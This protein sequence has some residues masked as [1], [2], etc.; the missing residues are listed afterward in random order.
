MEKKPWPILVLAMIHFME[1]IAKIFFYSWLWNQSPTIF[2]EPWTLDTAYFRALFFFGFPIAGFAIYMVKNWSLPVFMGVQAVTLIGHIQNFSR[3]PESFPVYLVAGVTALNCLVVCYF[4][5]PAVRA[6]YL[7]PRLRW[8]EAKPRYRVNWDFKCDLNG[9]SYKGHILNISE[10]GMFLSFQSPQ[11]F[12][13]YKMA[14]FEFSY[15]NFHFKLSGQ[16][17]HHTPVES[18]NTRRNVFKFPKPSRI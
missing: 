10:G 7:D 11:E 9:K 16:L 17:V 5:V 6:A 12:E 15:E 18:D 1:P 8:W 2:F 13:L 3:S 14:D 4:L